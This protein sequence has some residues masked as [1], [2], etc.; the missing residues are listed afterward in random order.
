[1]GFSVGQVPLEWIGVNAESAPEMFRPEHLH[2][3]W[4]A[5][6]GEPGYVTFHAVTKM[7]DHFATPG[8]FTGKP[9]WSKPAPWS[10]SAKARASSGWPGKP[11]RNA[12]G[13]PRERKEPLSSV[14]TPTL[15]RARKYT[16]WSNW[17]LTSPAATCR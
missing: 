15:L 10:N 7:L 4:R 12:A 6:I 9:P 2:A 1:M 3:N 17:F 8:K 16:Y 13:C 14:S 5:G 11:S